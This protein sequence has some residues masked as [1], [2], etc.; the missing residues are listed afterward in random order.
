MK[1]LPPFFALLALPLVAVAQS[2]G[3][4]QCTMGDLVRRVVVERQGSA[5]VPC[6]VAYYKDTEASG[7]RQVLWSAEHDPEYC[8]ARASEFR[9]KLEGMGWQC[10]AAN[11]RRDGA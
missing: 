1:L 4:Y 2:D 3:S 9:S 10:S 8:S 5:P 6:E 11:A 7:Q